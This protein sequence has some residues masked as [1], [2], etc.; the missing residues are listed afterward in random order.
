[1]NG[2]F[3]GLGSDSANNASIEVDAS[4]APGLLLT[5]CEFAAF[6]D[7]GWAPVSSAVPTQVL[8][9]ES[10]TGPANASIINGVTSKTERCKKVCVCGC[11][12][13]YLLV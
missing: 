6:H 10:N 5:N 13:Y 1:M 8:I 12:N 4:Q 11:S 7:S 2:N 3:L 9:D